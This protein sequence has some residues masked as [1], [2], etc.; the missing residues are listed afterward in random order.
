MNIT[1]VTNAALLELHRESTELRETAFQSGVPAWARDQQSARHD[2][3]VREMVRRGLLGARPAAR[4]WT[5]RSVA[6]SPA[7]LSV[8]RCGLHP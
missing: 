8:L 7:L 3:I 5:L 4:T 1:D 2:E 6:P